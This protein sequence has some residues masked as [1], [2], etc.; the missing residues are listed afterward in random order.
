MKTAALRVAIVHWAFPPTTGGVESH[1]ADLA[2]LLSGRGC[3][4]TVLTGEPRPVEDP[5]FSVIPVSTLRLVRSSGKNPAALTT[6]LRRLQ[7]HV[8]HGHNLHHFHSTPARVLDRLRDEIGFNLQHTFHETWP[9]VLHEDAVYRRWDRNWAVSA[10]VQDECERR[11]GF[12]PQLLRLPVDTELFRTSRKPLQNGRRPIILHPARLLPWKG[13]HVSV[14]MLAELRLR[15]YEATLVVT[16]TQRIADWDGELSAYRQ[17]VLEL[18][19]AHNLVDSVRFVRAAYAD[20]PALYDEADIVVYPTVGEEPYGL[21]PLEAMSCARPI[22][23]TRSGGICETVVDGET[24]FLVDRDDAVTLAKRVATILDDP[25]LAT[26]LGRKGRKRAAAE[27][28]VDRFLDT[29][30]A[31][32]RSERS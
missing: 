22:V 3:E 5:A 26:A 17:H 27:F 32:Y 20:M 11:I 8:V 1:L 31:A 2:R 28:G 10:H 4:V 15:G 9:D 29:L 21:V 14:A 30:L 7:P 12:R 16:D 24:G 18:I 6:V 13:V 19:R 23:A 25:A